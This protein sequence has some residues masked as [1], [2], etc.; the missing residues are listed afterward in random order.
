[1]RGAESSAAQSKE[2]RDCLPAYGAAAPGM[3]CVRACGLDARNAPNESE[4]A[5]ASYAHHARLPAC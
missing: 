3:P 2:V 5:Y 1:M 4:H